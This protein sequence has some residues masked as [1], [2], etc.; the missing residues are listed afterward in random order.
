M[1]HLILW[2]MKE[3]TNGD[4]CCSR[5][6]LDNSG[7]IRWW[8]WNSDGNGQSWWVVADCGSLYGVKD[9]SNGET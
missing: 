9:M 1:L 8:W 7:N 6:L 3:V 5:F 2:P 4:N